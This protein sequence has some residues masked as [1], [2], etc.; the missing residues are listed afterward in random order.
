MSDLLPC[1]FCGGE[2]VGYEWSD[3]YIID[4]GEPHYPDAYCA[5]KV[6]HKENCILEIGEFYM[7]VAP[8]EEQAAK[9]WN[10][11]H[12]K[13]S[14]VLDV[15]IGSPFCENCCYEDSRLYDYRYCPN[16]GYELVDNE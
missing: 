10:T 4:E 16:C 9:L 3:D 5:V 12:K 14:K 13:T 11:R 15:S 6:N 2:A 1:P 7:W 8:T